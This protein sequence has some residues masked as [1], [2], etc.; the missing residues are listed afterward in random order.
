MP[1]CQTSKVLAQFSTLGADLNRLCSPP[2]GLDSKER[3]LLLNRKDRSKSNGLK[4]V[5]IARGIVRLCSAV[6]AV[7]F[8]LLAGCSTVIPR[9]DAKFDAEP[10]GAPPIAPSPTPP[11]DQ[12]V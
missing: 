6:C 5:P 2:L 11:N 3:M 12:L 9:L 7:A 4:A 1:K 10:L 8:G